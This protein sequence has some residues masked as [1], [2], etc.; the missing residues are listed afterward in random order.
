M[1]QPEPILE[2]PPNALGGL[3]REEP[4]EVEPGEV[5]GGGKTEAGAAHSERCVGTGQVLKH[6]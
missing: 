5:D 3:K 1:A 4:R 6:G 2:C